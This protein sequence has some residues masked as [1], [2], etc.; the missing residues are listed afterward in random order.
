M[1]RK[2]LLKKKKERNVT[3]NIFYHYSII[4]NNFLK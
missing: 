2:N 1:M 4:I 3:Y